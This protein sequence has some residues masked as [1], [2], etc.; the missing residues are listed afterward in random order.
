M[1]FYIPKKLITLKLDLLALKSFF[2]FTDI[3]KTLFSKNEQFETDV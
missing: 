1:I 3:F 2:I